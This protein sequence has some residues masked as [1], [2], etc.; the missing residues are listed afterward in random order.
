MKYLAFIFLLGLIMGTTI[1]NT[2]KD[3]CN[4][5]DVLEVYRFNVHYLNGV[6][7]VS[8]PIKT[9]GETDKAITGLS[10][11]QNKHNLQYLYLGVN[12]TIVIDGKR[13]WLIP[14]TD[15]INY[16]I[17]GFILAR[18]TDSNKDGLLRLSSELST[19]FRQGYYNEEP[20]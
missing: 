15:D 18:Y 2:Y 14:I 1:D 9:F 12:Q 7:L 20:K 3:K 17:S 4:D 16:H 13:Y 5:K 6:P 10:N 11:A 19:R 8:D